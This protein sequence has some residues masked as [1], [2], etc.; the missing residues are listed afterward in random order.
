MTS[1]KSQANS[2]ASEPEVPDTVETRTVEATPAPKGEP[3][4]QLGPGTSDFEPVTL[5][6]RDGKEKVAISQAEVYNLEFA[7]YT[8]KKPAQS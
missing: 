6:G 5:Y 1:R 7:G 8:K 3:E 2:E 4:S